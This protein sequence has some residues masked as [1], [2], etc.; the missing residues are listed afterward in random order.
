MTA[1]T[2]FDPAL[3]EAGLADAEIGRTAK[4]I[5]ATLWTM[6]L[7]YIP[8]MFIQNKAWLALTLVLS[9]ADTIQAGHIAM[10]QTLSCLAIPII[11]RSTFTG[12]GSYAT[13]ILAGLYANGFTASLHLQVSHI[14][15]AV[16]WRR[17]LPVLALVAYGSTAA[18]SS[19]A[20]SLKTITFVGS[21]AMSICTA[22]IALRLAVLPTY[23][24]QCVTVA[25]A[26]FI[27][28]IANTIATS[29]GAG[30]DAL[31]LEGS[32]MSRDTDTGVRRS[33]DAVGTII[34]TY[35]FTA[36]IDV[37]ITF[38]SLATDL[39]PTHIRGGAIANYVIARSMQQ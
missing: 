30:G 22:W 25:A 3:N 11:A 35:W 17:A 14:T 19:L 4:T 1:L 20:I 2:S 16:S 7:A 23:G 36:A 6:R 26:T 15:I 34:I 28:L 33:A 39:N 37:R 5:G 10:R 13:S 9:N 32:H 12:F 18:V 21:H 24:I 27:L 8:L 29:Q 38:V 31:S